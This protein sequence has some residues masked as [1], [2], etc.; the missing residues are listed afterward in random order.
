MKK[1][2]TIAIAL[3][4]ISAAN[5]IYAGSISGDVRISIKVEPV[6]KLESD[7]SHD[8][9]KDEPAATLIQTVTE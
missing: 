6:L 8:V 7:S 4:V 9:K 3:C 2:I 5:N 1:P